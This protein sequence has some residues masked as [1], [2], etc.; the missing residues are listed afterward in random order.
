MDLL[1]YSKDMFESIPDFRKINLLMFII[2]KRDNLIRILVLESDINRFFEQ[3]KKI[4]NEGNED[5]LDYI[6]I[7]EESIDER[8]SYQMTQKISS[9]FSNK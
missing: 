5:Y 2:E 8:N 6:K 3:L 7:K 9:C 1:N 4:L